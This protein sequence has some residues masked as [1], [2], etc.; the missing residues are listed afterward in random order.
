ML[1]GKTCGNCA[2]FSALTN[3]CRRKAPTAVMIQKP[4]GEPAS[5]GVFPATSKDR[6]CG[7]W[8]AEETL[9]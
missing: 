7:E 2:A 8:L 1:A 5:I 9:Q 6:W 4:D 3:E